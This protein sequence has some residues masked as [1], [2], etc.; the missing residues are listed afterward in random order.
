M[1]RKSLNFAKTVK[2]IAKRRE[3][4]NKKEKIVPFFRNVLDFKVRGG[5]SGHRT[6]I[7]WL[8]RP[9]DVNILLI[10]D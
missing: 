10:F 1:Q 9:M 6:S 2:T 3:T 7:G 5:R 4:Y 8:R